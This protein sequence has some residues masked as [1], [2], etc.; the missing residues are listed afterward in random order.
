MTIEKRFMDE[1]IERNKGAISEAEDNLYRA[2]Q[3]VFVACKKCNDEHTADSIAEV[4]RRIAKYKE[5]KD[6][7]AKCVEWAHYI[8]TMIANIK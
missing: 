3:N 5:A 7:R 8:N 4:E 6:E 1:M 2:R